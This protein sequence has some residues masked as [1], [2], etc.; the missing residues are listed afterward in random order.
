MEAEWKTRLRQHTQAGCDSQFGGTHFN[1]IPEETGGV[2]GA[3]VGDHQVLPHA[4]FSAGGSS[5]VK[6]CAG[7]AARAR[8]SVRGGPPFGLVVGKK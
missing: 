8:A 3:V 1:A 5:E 6:P 2:A 4:L 7:A